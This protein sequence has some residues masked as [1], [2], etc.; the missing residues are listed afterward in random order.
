M[1]IY[2]YYIWRGSDPSRYRDLHFIQRQSSAGAIS[3]KYIS[4]QLKFRGILGWCPDRMS[5]WPRSF[6]GLSCETIHRAGGV[7][8]TVLFALLVG[9]LGVSEPQ[10]KPIKS[11]AALPLLQLV[12]SPFQKIRGQVIDWVS[13][14]WLHAAIATFKKTFWC[15]HTGIENP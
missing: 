11:I 15:F 9:P 13:V 5:F 3:N 2:I 8:P 4:L 10:G 12:G 6:F 14:C 1:C 7:S